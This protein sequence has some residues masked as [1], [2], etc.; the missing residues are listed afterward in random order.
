MR[1][2]ENA[3]AVFAVARA[4][5]R[6]LEGRF[7]DRLAAVR[8]FGS[9]ARGDSDANSDID[10]LVVIRDLTEPERTEAVDLAL[11]AWRTDRSTGPVSPLVWSQRE[12]DDRVR[13]ERRIARDIIAEGFPL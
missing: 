1:S 10:V 9:Q 4:Y 13:S 7:G 11:D 5:R 2:P 3:E 6:L 12:F 8:L